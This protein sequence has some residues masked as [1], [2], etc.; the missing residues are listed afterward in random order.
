MN[1][2]YIEMLKDLQVKYKHEIYNDN[3]SISNCDRNTPLF[4]RKTAIMT[5]VLPTIDF[6]IR[7]LESKSKLRSL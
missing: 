6:M 2:K 3:C 7:E 1:N 5:S 4:F